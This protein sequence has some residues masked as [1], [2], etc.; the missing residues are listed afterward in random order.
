MKYAQSWY[1]KEL[2]TFEIANSVSADF[3]IIN[4][5][6]IYKRISSYNQYFF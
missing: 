6:N 4:S 1:F 3:S 2:I 5:K